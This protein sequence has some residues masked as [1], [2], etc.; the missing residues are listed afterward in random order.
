M[1][2]L[3]HDKNSILLSINEYIKSY[4]LTSVNEWNIDTIRINF[5]K[6]Y[7]LERLKQI[8][9]WH[10]I[11]SSSKISIKLKKMILN[12]K[13]FKSIYQLNDKNIY[14]YTVDDKQHRKAVLVIFGITQY[15][16]DNTL[17]GFDMVTVDKLLHTLKNVDSVDLCIDF[18]TPPNK[19]VIYDLFKIED[20]RVRFETIYINKTNILMCDKICIYNKQFKDNL[21]KPLYR[22]EATIT[23]PNIKDLVIPLYELNNIIKKLWSI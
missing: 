9:S 6:Q 13:E 11:K 19:D 17:R 8:G 2:V 21:I 3:K 20:T 4:N 10:K 16:E 14:Y 23:I 5:S 1:C 18:D 22:F 15:N 7:K 12:K